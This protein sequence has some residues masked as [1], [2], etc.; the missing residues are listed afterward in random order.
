M[1]VILALWSRNLRIFWR[2]KPALI[3]N[4]TLPF[5]FLFIFGGVFGDILAM[6]VG[7]I[8]ATMF[9]S[10]F[11]IS[12]STVD[13]MTGGFM[14]EVLVSPVPRAYISIGQFASSA[15]IAAVQGTLILI[16]GFALG[17]RINSVFTLVFL[18]LTMLLIGITYAGFGLLIATKAKNTQTFQAFSMAVTMPMTFM[19]GAYIPISSMPRALQWLAFFNPLTYTVNLFRAVS[20]GAL[21]QDFEFLYENNM[22]VQFWGMRIGTLESGIITAVFGIVFIILSSRSFAKLD[23]SKMNRQPGAFDIWS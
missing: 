13:D 9:D 19:S 3:V 16:G 6:L 7:I 4:M 22:A 18:L 20:L 8:A 14:R 2:N 21:G 5:F 17:Y 15:T 10:A 12:S 23:F 1:E 11:R